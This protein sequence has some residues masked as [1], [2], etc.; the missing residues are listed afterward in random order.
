[1]NSKKRTPL[2]LALMTLILCGISAHTILAQDNTLFLFRTTGVDYIFNQH[3]EVLSLRSAYSLDK[4]S[5]PLLDDRLYHVD[6]SPAS[7]SNVRIHTNPNFYSY[8][9]S[10]S[11][12]NYIEN[13]SAKPAERFNIYGDARF[14][15]EANSAFASQKARHREVLRARIGAEYK[16]ND[17]FSSG[18]RLVTGSLDDPNASD[19]TIGNFNDNFEASFDLAY[20][21]FNYNKLRLDVGKFQN[22]LPEQIS[23][24]MGM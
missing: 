15:Y 2:V 5:T 8:F 23:F 16:L 7:Q 19:E 13:K 14:R 1:M 22:P 11:A 17:Y 24:G 6:E 18:A 21:T 3:S 20:L 10:Q 4:I 12:N 9:Y